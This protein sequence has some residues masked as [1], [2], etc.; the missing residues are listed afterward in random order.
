MPLCKARGIQDHPGAPSAFGHFERAPNQVAPCPRSPQATGMD[1]HPAA[2]L[3]PPQTLEPEQRPRQIAASSFALSY[4]HPFGMQFHMDSLKDLRVTGQQMSRG[5]SRVCSDSSRLAVCVDDPHLR[6]TQLP[7]A[8]LH[9][10]PVADHHPGDL[11]GMD[12]ALGRRSM[13][14]SVS[15]RTFAEYVSK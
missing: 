2:P 13:S 6:H 3:P 15:A 4:R 9:F 1:L 8:H 10:R 7:Q 14:R 11:V 5:E 12:Q